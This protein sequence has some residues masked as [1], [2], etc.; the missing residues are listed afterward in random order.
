MNSSSMESRR[1][2]RSIAHWCVTSTCRT[3]STTST[4]WKGFWSRTR[5][6]KSER[7]RASALLLWLGERNSGGGAIAPLHLGLA[8]RLFRIELEL[9]RVRQVAAADRD[10]TGAALGNVDDEAIDHWR[11]TAGIGPGAHAR[12]TPAVDAPIATFEMGI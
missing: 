8:K 10:D 1:P 9:E 6:S 2:C 3:A 4:G 5:R 12:R 11:H 7:G